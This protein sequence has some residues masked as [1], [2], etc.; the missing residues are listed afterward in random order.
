MLVSPYKNLASIHDV[1]SLLQMTETLALKAVD[2]FI[3]YL[4]FAF[5]HF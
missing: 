5:A 3:L 1:Q 4:S 2:K